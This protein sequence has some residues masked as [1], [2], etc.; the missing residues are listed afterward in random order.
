[1]SI[2]LDALEGKQVE[3]TPVAPLVTMGHAAVVYGAAF[4]DYMLKPEIYAGAQVHAKRFYGYD[5]VWAHQVF[6]GVTDEERK[7]IEKKEDY[8][9]LTLETG[10]KYKIPAEGAPHIIE[11]AI[12]SKEALKELE[13]PD[14]S[15]K[16]RT[17]PIKLMLE[18]EEFVAGNMRCPFT[19]ASDYL[20]ELEKFLIDLKLDKP[21]IRRLLDFSLEYCAESI[22]AQISAGVSAIFVEDPNASPNLISP[23]DA[24]EFAFPY[25]QKLVK[26]IE[27]EVPVIL[28][29]CGNVESVLD[30]MA[31]T[32]ANAISVDESVSMEKVLGKNVAA[33]GNVAPK[34]LARGSREEVKKACGDIIK[35]GDGIVLS[36]GCVVPKNARQEN[37]KEMVTAAKAKSFKKFSKR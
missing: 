26:R 2:L 12:S 31:K 5:W 29:I 24:R 27:G 13:I 15:V 30:D 32:K 21:F 14:F 17:L 25:T 23:K 10:V 22:K 4:R 3:R 34:I 16:E 11:R 20:Y 7:S 9:I 33:W 28:H 18:K 37:V 6:Q 8:M 36:S 35:L 19:L 1:M